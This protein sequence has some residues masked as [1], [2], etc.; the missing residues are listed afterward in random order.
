[1]GPEGLARFRR[2]PSPIPVGWTAPQPSRLRHCDDQTLAA[3]GAVYAALESPDRPDP[4]RFRDWGVVAAPRF[5]GRA[6]G[7]DTL[8]QFASEGAWGVTPHL[9]AHHTLHS[10]SGTLSQVLGI[11]GPNLGVGGGADAAVQGFVTAL[12]WLT[13]G[14]VPGVWIVMSGWTPEYVPDGAGHPVGVPECLALALGLVPT[15][16]E[17]RGLPRIRL[18]PTCPGFPSGEVDLEALDVRLRAAREVR[19]PAR[20]TGSDRATRV[21]VGSA[22]YRLDPGHAVGGRTVVVARGCGVQVELE[23]AASSGMRRSG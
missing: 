6:T 12:T 10:Q 14:T 7:A 11:H 19:G 3:L 13:T 18:R 5:L 16:P 8:A 21:R 23:P 1:M 15:D 17:R 22:T 20:E 2:H 4:G 9:I